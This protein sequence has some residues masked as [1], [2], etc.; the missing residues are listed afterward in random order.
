PNF[1][2][3]TVPEPTTLGTLALGAI[4]LVRRRSSRR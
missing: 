1:K 4:A 3:S 2:F